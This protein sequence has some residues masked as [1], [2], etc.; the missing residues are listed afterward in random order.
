MNPTSTERP[1]MENKP[2]TG[3]NWGLII[4]L[5]VMVAL[6]SGAMVRAYSEWS[7]A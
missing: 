2:Q 1:A 5:I 6:Y 4:L 3:P 7:A